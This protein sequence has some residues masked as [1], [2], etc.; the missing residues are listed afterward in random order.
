MII[1]RLYLLKRIVGACNKEEEK[2]SSF[3]SSVE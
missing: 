3:G 2:V 1:T